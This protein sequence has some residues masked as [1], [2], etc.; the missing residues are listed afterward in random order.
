MK[1]GRFNQNSCILPLSVCA[2]LVLL[3]IAINSH[4][5]STK[6]FGMNTSCK[7]FVAYVSANQDKI[8]STNPNAQG[9][10]DLFGETTWDF[11]ITNPMVHTSVSNGAAGKKFICA[12]SGKAV[13]N[14]EVEC[15][16]GLKC[17][18]D[19]QCP[20]GQDC[21]NYDCVDG[22]VTGLSPDRNAVDVRLFHWSP[23]NNTKQ[24]GASITQFNNAV[25]A[26][27]EGHQQDYRRDIND[28]LARYPASHFHKHK[29]GAE[30]NAIEQEITSEITQ[31]VKDA[32]DERDCSNR[33]G[34]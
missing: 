33:S 19:F 29:C 16:V 6:I 30:I 23:Q 22:D 2:G 20:K 3:M 5:D 14:Y 4:A 28:W 21:K 27:E 25:D 9:D 7:D 31:Q 32:F 26:H 11:H 13:D 34:C 1:R 24:C 10:N 17:F 12:C 15:P 18:G 8:T